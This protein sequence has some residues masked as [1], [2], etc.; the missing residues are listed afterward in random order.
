MSKIK[1]WSDSEINIYNDFLDVPYS[2]IL[3]IGPKTKSLINKIRDKSSWIDNS[4][5]TNNPPD[6]YSDKYK[7]MMDFMRIS[8]CEF[9]TKNGKIVNPNNIREKEIM[10]GKVEN[11]I[12]LIMNPKTGKK[13]ER[14]IPDFKEPC[15]YNNR[16]KSFEKT[17]IKHKNKINIYKKNHPGF[18]TIF[19][20]Y[21]DSAPYIIAPHGII[22]P[23]ANT[24]C[25]SYGLYLYWR[26][27]KIIDVLQKD[28]NIPDYV[29]WYTP[30][31]EGHQIYKADGTLLEINKITLFAPNIIAKHF[32]ID[33]SNKNILC[34]ESN[35][36]DI[37]DTL[38]GEQK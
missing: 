35:Q 33:Y 9:E 16:I 36:D 6:F 26:D 31:V 29:L 10:N 37:F 11:G 25:N 20:I 4:S 18:K 27:K 1:I 17:I 21:D 30:N 22:N 5:N 2:K 14:Y 7:L 8:D 3:L 32:V 13:I 15:T 24:K 28:G 23:K 38:K 19:F 12:I 34:S